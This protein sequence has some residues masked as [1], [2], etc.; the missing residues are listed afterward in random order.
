[1]KTMKQ[2]VRRFNRMYSPEM[3]AWLD[4]LESYP[5]LYRVVI[6]DGLGMTSRYIFKTCGEFMEWMNGIC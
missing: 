2:L 6:T 1:M 3:E 4:E 5:G